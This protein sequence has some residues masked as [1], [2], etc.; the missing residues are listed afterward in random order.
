MKKMFPSS[1]DLKRYKDIARLLIKYGLSD[2]VFQSQL[3]E[4]VYDPEADL[5]K[6]QSGKAEELPRDL[7]RLGGSF[8][9]F[10]QFMCAFTDIL[11]ASYIDALTRLNDQVE[12][13]EF[14]EVESI[15]ESELGVR[16]HKAFSD[17]DQTPKS[18]AS[19][20]QVHRASL[21]DGREVAVKVQRPG[22]RKDILSDLELL[23]TI[24][25]ML[26]E[27]TKIG[28]TNQ[29]HQIVLDFRRRILQELDFRLEAQN[30]RKMQGYLDEF[31]SI[32]LPE[33]IEDYTSNRVLT[34]TYIHGTS[35]TK[36]KPLPASKFDRSQLAEEFFRAYL[37]QLLVE[38]FFHADPHPGNVI[39]TNDGHLALL[40][41]GMVAYLSEDD[42]ETL[43]KILIAV[44][45]GDGQKVAQEALKIAERPD[46][47]KESQFEREICELVGEKKDQEAGK[48]SVGQLV[49]KVSEIAKRYEIQI[50]TI[51]TLL[52]KTLLNMDQ[53]GRCLAPHFNSNECIQREAASLIRHRVWKSLSP[54]N[55]FNTMIEIKDLFSRMPYRMN[56]IIRSLAENQLEIKVSA[57]DEDRLIAG[58]QKIANRIAM[59]LI[60]ASLIIGA[61]LM[62][63]IDTP[64]TILGFPIIALI[65][66][67]LAACGGV[68]MILR[69]LFSDE[70]PKK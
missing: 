60:L 21:R 23:E 69:I 46:H 11:P 8:I 10:G 44:S 57:I 19:L 5:P 14:S 42:Q 27:H 47:L 36:V 7:E 43:L 22:I 12:P 63:T 2:I 35:V 38:G 68:A 50:P 39:L 65:F 40:D 9:K 52:G 1:I 16:L 4:Y 41:L 18:A 62:M 61:A 15:V 59:G 31:P 34:M 51:L 64:Y 66:F 45:E 29:Y 33:P 53:V 32:I 25:S 20:S 6:K 30:L 49:L 26:E 28:K 37:K 58:F 17:F 70:H 54:G 67:L 3:Q 24:A 48:F 56:Q 13:F 55:F